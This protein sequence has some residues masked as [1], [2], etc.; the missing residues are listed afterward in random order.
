[1]FRKQGLVG[2]R[3]L[4]IAVVL[5]VHGNEQRGET[6]AAIERAIQEA[7]ATS[8]PITALRR[9]GQ[10]YVNEYF[11]DATRRAGPRSF[12]LFLVLVVALTVALYRSARTLLAFLL[13]L[14]ACMATS[15]GYI[16]LTGGNFSVVSPMVP[17]TILV[18]ATATLVYLHSRFV[19][20]P[21]GRSVDEHQV[22]ALTNKFLACT[23][24][25][26]A[27]LNEMFGNRT[28]CGIGRGDSA[29]R[30]TNGK[31]T[32]VRDMREAT[33]VIRELANCRAVD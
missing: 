29:V 33:H 1:M 4:S 32:T 16:G 19:E 24:S 25:I 15:V 27:T 21:E 9:V 26:F 14:G 18:T 7:E 8:P 31:P 17:M 5:D 20:R 23:A 3:F 10:P 13:T 22:F 2:D 12:G 28:V 11:D 6:L 30:V